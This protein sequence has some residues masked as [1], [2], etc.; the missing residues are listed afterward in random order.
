MERGRLS[1]NTPCNP[2][3][4]PQGQPIDPYKQE[5]N[6]YKSKSTNAFTSTSTSIS[7]MILKMK[8]NP[9]RNATVFKTPSKPL[10]IHISSRTLAYAIS[11]RISNESQNSLL[12]ISQEELE[13][14]LRYNQTLNNY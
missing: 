8:R 6:P 5:L 3:P 13:Y 7:A 9:R 1:L 10:S 14:K 2:L 11:I 12:L 4:F